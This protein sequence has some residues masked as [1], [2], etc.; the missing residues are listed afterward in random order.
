MRLSRSLPMRSAEK[1]VTPARSAALTYLLTGRDGSDYYP[2][3]GE[4]NR[5]SRSSSSRVPAGAGRTGTKIGGL[6]C[7]RFSRQRLIRASSPSA[8]RFKAPSAGPEAGRD[9]RA[10]AATHFRSC[11][12]TPWV[13]ASEGSGATPTRSLPEVEVKC[14]WWV[15]ICPQ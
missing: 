13:L 7:Q 14:S 11:R 4:R 10:I 5:G 6:G 3:R 12:A 15:L 9:E 8:A 1:P 2:A